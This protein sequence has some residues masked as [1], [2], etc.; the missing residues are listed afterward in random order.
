MLAG[1]PARVDGVAVLANESF[2]AN[3][4]HPGHEV[5]FRFW[6]HGGF[7]HAQYVMDSLKEARQAGITDFVGLVAEVASVVG[8][9]VPCVEL[10]IGDL[11]VHEKTVG[12]DMIERCRKLRVD[13]NDL[14]EFVDSR[15][16]AVL[17]LNGEASS[18][19]LLLKPPREIRDQIEGFP[20]FDGSQQFGCMAGEFLRRHPKRN[21]RGCVP[22]RFGHA[23]AFACLF[24]QHA[25]KNAFGFFIGHAARLRVALQGWNRAAPTER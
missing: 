16:L 4:V 24:P 23:V 11:T 5:S 6:R 12:L 7:R 21:S 9:D 8:Q 3:L 20:F 2:G 14:A 18:V 10:R 17:F 15:I 1:S 13:G 19:E 25:V 22:V